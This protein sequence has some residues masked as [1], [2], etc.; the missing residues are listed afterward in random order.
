MEELYGWVRNLAG[1]FI[2]LSVL[3]NLI[4]SKSYGRYIR[5][6]AG[7]VLILLVVRPLTGSLGLEDR[8]A[9]FYEGL[10]FRY[11]ADGLK[12]DILGIEQQRREQMIDRYEQAVAE[13]VERMAREEGFTVVG[14]RAAISREEGTE[15]FGT[16]TGIWL[17]VQGKGQEGEGKEKVGEGE[18]KVEGRFGEEEGKIGEGK[19]GEKGGNG[20][21]KDEE[22]EKAAVSSQVS[23]SIPP[24]EIAVEAEKS[25]EA[26]G[27]TSNAAVDEGVGQQRE[28]QWEGQQWKEQQWKEQQWEGQQWKEQQREEQNRLRKRI[29]AYYNLEESYVEIQVVEGEG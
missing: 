7:M 3:D 8:I 17:Q 19:T 16:V 10:V 1:Y 25:A 27:G 9:G 23:V 15:R 6:F 21:E 2:F 4:P 5:L 14:S 18:R 24:V 22:R 29:S 28:Q 12:Q 13:D 11:Q 20:K 26:A